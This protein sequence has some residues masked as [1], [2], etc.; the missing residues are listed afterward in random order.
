MEH[1]WNSFG[2]VLEHLKPYRIRTRN[3]WN[4]FAGVDFYTRTH[5]R[6]RT[7]THARARTHARRHRGFSVEVFQC[8]NCSKSSLTQPRNR[9]AITLSRQP[10]NRAA[11]DCWSYAKPWQ[12]TT[13]D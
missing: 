12:L 4:S 2:T 13:Y 3:S 9:D 1:L 10:L 5:A 6:A 7:R 11:Q 8:S